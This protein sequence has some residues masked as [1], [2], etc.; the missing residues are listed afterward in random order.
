MPCDVG[1][2]RW[3]SWSYS[4]SY[5]PP[6]RPA[7]EVL[8]RE[9]GITVGP[10]VAATGSTLGNTIAIEHRAVPRTSPTIVHMVTSESKATAAIAR[11]K[12]P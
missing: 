4:S 6:C 10:T 2:L 7:Q 5:L 11:G 1:L 9:A 12:L 8:I 3:H